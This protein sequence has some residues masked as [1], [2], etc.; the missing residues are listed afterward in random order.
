MYFFNSIAGGLNKG[1]GNGNV[2]VNTFLNS[3]QGNPFQ[4]G[5]NFSD[6]LKF[7]NLVDS[8]GNN[9]NNNLLKSQE[10]KL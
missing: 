4:S 9:N 8:N 10:V 5:L 2:N 3:K 1:N 7:N 6:M